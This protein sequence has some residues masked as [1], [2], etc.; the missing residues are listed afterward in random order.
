[1][2]LKTMWKPVT[3][4]PTIPRTLV[5]C[6]AQHHCHLVV[7]TSLL[8]SRIVCMIKRSTNAEVHVYAEV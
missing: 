5:N 3:S 1:M 6:H 4:V 8:L 7:N 2:H